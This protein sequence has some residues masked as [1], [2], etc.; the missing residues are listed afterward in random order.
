MCTD[1]QVRLAGGQ[2]VLMGRV[3]VC[4]GEQ[5]GTI[6][7]LGFDRPEASVVCGQL[8]Y[9]RVSKFKNSCRLEPF[10]TYVLALSSQEPVPLAVLLMV[11]E[12]VASILQVLDV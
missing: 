3:E 4:I 8:G 12:R 6:C 10:S 5:Y 11:L 9:S 2:S 7:D 1:G